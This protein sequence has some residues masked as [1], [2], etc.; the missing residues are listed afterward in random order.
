MVKIGPNSETDHCSCMLHVQNIII[1]IY[2][3]IQ[4]PLWS[5]LYC[6]E[7]SLGVTLQHTE[8]NSLMDYQQAR[9]WQDPGWHTVKVKAH[10]AS[11]ALSTNRK[12][13][14]NRIIHGLLLMSWKHP[15]STAATLLLKQHRTKYKTHCASNFHRA[16]CRISAVPQLKRHRPHA[17]SEGQQEVKNCKMVSRPIGH[18]SAGLSTWTLT[19][20][21]CALSGSDT[22]VPTAPESSWLVK[23]WGGKASRPRK[24]STT[25]RGAPRW[26]I[27]TVPVTAI[28]IDMFPH[29]WT[30]THILTYRRAHTVYVK[31]SLR[32]LTV[33]R[34]QGAE[35]GGV[36]CY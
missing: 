4:H 29:L 15:S 16:T 1:S 2:N 21:S 24:R 5:L 31:Y 7:N 14:Y 20:G 34:K 32:L 17:N 35:E 26:I 36:K 30:L 10:R 25:F 11:R 28:S 13:K 23:S 19:S 8:I 22:C 18:R 27:Q 9:V 6:F 3:S 12:S 33:G